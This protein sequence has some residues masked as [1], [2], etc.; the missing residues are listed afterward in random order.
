MLASG[1]NPT[2][3]GYIPVAIFFVAAVVVPL[4]LLAFSRALS[5]RV[6]GDAKLQ[7]YE[8]GVDPIG[9]ARERFSVRYYL[10]AMLF[11]IFDVEAVFLIP[12]GVIFAKLS[13]FGLIEMIVFIGILVVGFYYAW[14]KG[15][16]EWV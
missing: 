1:M 15:A 10:I 11:L 16:L 2:I 6:H 14:R 7:P 12:W 13:I 8:C 9:G 4:A 3:Y 5:H